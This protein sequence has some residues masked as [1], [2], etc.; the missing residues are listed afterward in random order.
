M[1]TLDSD[2]W[3][4]VGR[5]AGD[6]GAR[7]VGSAANRAAA[8]Y[9]AGVFANAGLTVERQPF[10]CP[11]WTDEGTTLTLDGH[12]LEA[13]A[14]MWSPPC[15]VSAPA[16]PVCTL[17]ELEGA[18]LDGRIALLYGE[19][20]ERPITPK[21]YPLYSDERDLRID[22]ALEGKGT[23]AALTV[24]H[25]RGLER[26]LEDADLAVPSAT[27]GPDT[28][29]ALLARP[30]V[31]VQLR[32]RTRR[33]PS[34]GAHVIGLKTGP[35]PARVLLCAHFDTKIGTPGAWDNASGTAALLALAGLLA[36][37]SLGC[38]LEFL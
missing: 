34:T 30:G 3:Q 37:E 35:R 19:L 1:G 10:D 25:R 24:Q 33:E 13:A 18:D 14:N 21:G 32:I 8:D 22:A 36:H 29:R 12:P 38:G 15:D 9:V 6:L 5:L 26:I 20:S 28:A 7:P 31:P 11:D 27:I 2:L 16:V 17:A 4:H 23:A